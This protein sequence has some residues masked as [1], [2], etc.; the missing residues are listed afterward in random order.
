MRKDKQFLKSIAI[1]TLL[2]TGFTAG[3]IAQDATTIVNPEAESPVILSTNPAGGEENVDLRSVIEITFSSEM[4]ETT[5]NENTLKLYITSAD[6]MNKDQGENMDDRIKERSEKKDSE[7]DWQQNNGAVS[8]TISYSGNVAVFEPDTELKEGAEYTFT[9]TS[10]VKNSENIALENEHNWSFSTNG[11]S[12]WAYTENQHSTLD[13]DRYGLENNQY[14][15]SAA[16]TTQKS[17]TTMIDLGKAGQFVIL[18]KT[19]IHNGSE[20]MITGRTGEGSVSDTTE[21]EKTKE[22]KAFADSVRQTTSDEVIVWQSDQSDTT[23][24]DVSEAI[25]DM[26]SAYNNASSQNGNDTAS[27][28]NGSFQD[29]TLTSG[30]HEWSDSLHIHYDVTLSGSEEDVWLFKVGSDLMIDENIVITLTDGARADN[31]FWFVE[32]EVTIGK[33]AQ[34]EGIILSKNDIKLENGAKLNGRMFSQTS[35]T[36]D[37]NTVTEPRSMAGQTTSTNR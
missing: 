21:T 19:N 3:S 2:F 20:S 35:I 27:H 36:L 24:Q 29:S 31:V 30:T 5:I 15:D 6:S 23:S 12:D 28:K 16:D 8:G 4:D 33:N 37:D 10:G 11:S 9:V 26:M 34:F 13:T 32:G 18:A 1:T 22:E 25:E 7:K 17:T 14:R